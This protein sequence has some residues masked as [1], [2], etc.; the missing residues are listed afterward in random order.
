MT[1]VRPSRR[2]PRPDR[3]RYPDTGSAPSDDTAGAD[4]LCRRLEGPPPRALPDIP[5]RHHRADRR[6]AATATAGHPGAV[7]IL[8]LT[9]TTSPDGPPVPA[10]R[11]PGVLEVPAG[12]WTPPTMDRGDPDARRRGTRG[13]DRPAC[14]VLAPARAVLH[15][16]GLHRADVP[17]P[18]R[19]CDPRTRTDWGRTRTSAC[20]WNGPGARHR[21]GGLGRSRT[22]SRS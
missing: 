18:R 5:R 2:E 22:P 13:G 10:R 1:A 6:D 8:A 11:G 15:G 12:R 7:A 3:R 20:S 14:G 19:T 17:V 4:L 21:H 9:P 16:A